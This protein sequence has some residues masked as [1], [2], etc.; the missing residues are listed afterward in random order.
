M[1]IV[2]YRHDDA[3]AR[4]E[5]VSLYDSV[6]WMVYTRTLEWLDDLG[7]MLFEDEPEGATPDQRSEL[8]FQVSTKL[9]VHLAAC[10]SSSVSLDNGALSLSATI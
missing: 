1:V 9:R 3:P 8:G 4:E 6:G 10:R 7:L 5:L 2:T